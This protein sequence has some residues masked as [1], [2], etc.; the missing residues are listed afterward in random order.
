VLDTT[1]SLSALGIDSLGRI[2]IS[3]WCKTSLRL[4]I[5]V[6]DIT[7]AETITKLAQI[8]LD[9]LRAKFAKKA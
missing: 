8:A 4:D 5:G 7:A 6:F 9:G 3:N 2:E 1:K